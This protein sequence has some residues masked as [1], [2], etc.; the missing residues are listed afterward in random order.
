MTPDEQWQLTHDRAERY[1]RY[2]V[3]RH[4]RPIAE[5]LLRRVPVH[6]DDRVLD[7]ACGTGIVARL[8]ASQRQAPD[9]II[10][11][12]LNEGMLAVAG[13]LGR[14]SATTI[15]WRQGDLMAL[16]FDDAWFT[17]ALCQQGLQFVPD[18][19]RA[20]NEMH[21]VL[22]PGGRL[23][24]N[25]FGAPSA[26]HIALAR[27]L[28]RFGAAKAARLSLA[29]FAFPDVAT[30]VG[31]VTQAGFA[32]VQ[33]STTHIARR[34]EPTQ[35]WLL[36]YSSALPYADAV[37]AMRAP[38]RAEMLRD[39]AVALKDLWVPD[40]TAGDSFVVPCEVHFVVA[41]KRSDAPRNERKGVG[42]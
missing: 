1:E 31:L 37:A 30:L 34:V 25:L 10:G 12:D 17:L 8:V 2:A 26:F 7:A 3:A 11:L 39:I 32:D 22:A 9:S 40:A 23:A 41:R 16:P 36:E 29:P 38:A 33:A 13:R 20:L 15:E 19:L 14:E 27:G 18:R 5:E 42:P 35:A 6:P 21:R 28:A 4:L 24:L